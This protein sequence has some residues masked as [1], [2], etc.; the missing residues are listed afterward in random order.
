M[1]KRRLPNPLVTYE[2]PYRQIICNLII[3][4]AFKVVSLQTIQVLVLGSLMT[5]KSCNIFFAKVHAYP[6]DIVVYYH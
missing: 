1:K 2:N 4:I 3:H 6:F 5:E